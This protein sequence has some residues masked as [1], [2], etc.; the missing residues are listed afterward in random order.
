V[1][2]RPGGGGIVHIANRGE[3][4][5]PVTV[6]ITTTNGGTVER[7]IPLEHWLAGHRSADVELPREVGSITRV[8]IDPEGATPDVTRANNFWPRG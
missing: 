3:A 8:E 1:D 7:S 4:P 6:R 5:F 2:P